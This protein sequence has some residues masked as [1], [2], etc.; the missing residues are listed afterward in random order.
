[1]NVILTHE[2]TDFD[3]VASL[4]G[5]HKLFP[6]YQPV[7]PRQLNRNVRD[8]LTLHWDALPFKRQDELPPRT[9]FERVV[10]VE[11][12]SFPNLKGLEPERLRDVFVIDHHER[13]EDL[14]PTW[15]FEGKS[16]GACTAIFVGHIAE[17]H[18]A[19]SAVEATLLLLGIY[20][21]TGSL[22]YAGTTPVDLHAAAWLLE[23]GANLDV[24]RDYLNHPLSDAQRA[25]YEQ[26]LDN[27]TFYDVNGYQ[28][29]IATA[30]TDN[31]VEEISTLAHSL[32]E[33]YDPDALFLLVEMAGHIQIVARATTDAVPVGQLMEHFGG[34]GHDRAAA[35]F[36]EGQALEEVRDTLLDLLRREVR[37]A[38]RVVD[39]MS[40]GQI[41]TL[42]PTETIGAAAALMR[43]WGHE[44][45]PVVDRQ[46]Q[47]VGVL[48]RRDVDR[49]MQHK[50]GGAPVADFMHKGAITVTPQAGIEQV[51]R[52]MTEHMVGQVPVV[53]GQPP[54]IV[55][56]ITRTDLLKLWGGAPTAGEQRAEIIRRLEAAVSP[57]TLRL[58]RAIAEEANAMG[59][60]LYFVG[61][62]VRDLLLG[63]P[64]KDL[65]LVVEGDAGALAQ[66]L[67]ARYGGRIVTHRRFGTAKWFLNE[68]ERPRDSLIT[69]PGLPDHIDLV[70]ARTEFYEHPTALPEVEESSI[71]LD[72]H[73]RDFTINTLAIALDEDRFGQL[74]D[75][76]GG[77]QDLA[78]RRVRVLHQ[79]SF[80]DDP[81]RILRAVRFAERLGFELE[82]RTRELLVN[83]LELLERVS[84]DRI[85]HELD[86]IFAEPEP[87]C[88]LQRLDQLGV[89]AAIDP[90]L[91]VDAAV[92]ERFRRL[93]AS[94]LPPDPEAYLALLAYDL[95]PI[96]RER[97]AERLML[98]R[99]T[100]VLLRTMAALREAAPH[101][102]Q[103]ELGRS[104]LDHALSD[105]EPRAIE[106]VA[107][108]THN[109]R[110]RERLRFY[111]DELRPLTLTVSGHDLRALG[112]PPGPVYG[113]ILNAVRA[114][115][116]DGLVSTPEEERE[117]LAGL[118]AVRRSHPQA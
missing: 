32:R 18:L 52:I 17:R 59:A 34:G 109:P 83:S 14:P 96:E 21:D 29:L 5:A 73:R 102:T 23:H 26:L 111:L 57:A 105:V 36:A 80:V 84:G 101:L 79:L 118:V 74:L 24:V 67:V 9:E 71:K 62:F 39:L 2:H 103:P 88:A 43:R 55:G 97:L 86:Q 30:R 117:L 56:I 69:A 104:A 95:S 4:L 41:R 92:V 1:M 35:A 45:F 115:R 113:E 11:T 65:D 81:T 22:T 3:A 90:A 28:V 78:E 58:V 10:L 13:R 77:A 108:A 114:A 46:G 112:L 100:R 61:G 33:L 63:Q 16:M 116:L 51:Q 8:F 20:E 31:Y 91:H 82:S 72:L 66:G 40:R 7:L 19:L 89:L 25:L 87:E 27:A 49:A 70:T 93:R 37:P 42:Q 38:V 94:S 15:R 60:S 64:V 54:E 6:D 107:L 98:V 48:T 44:G 110:L 47:V 106:L 99:D 75:F 53:E 12:Q 85:R 50:L 76:Y 68:D